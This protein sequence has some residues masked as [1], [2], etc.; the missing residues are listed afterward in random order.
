PSR[1]SSD[2]SVQNN[3]VFFGVRGIGGSRVTVLYR[4]R[5]S[6][7]VIAGN[8]LRRSS[9]D[10]VRAIDVGHRRVPLHQS[11]VHGRSARVAL[12]LIFTSTDGIKTAGFL[13]F[14]DG[15][16]IVRVTTTIRSGF[17]TLG[18]RSQEVRVEDQ[19]TITQ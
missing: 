14:L 8:V 10:V 17:P 7:V 2:L 6:N 16:I 11:T 13:G 4:V 19:S 15:T 12:E 18:A 9:L 3:L 5:A 1:R